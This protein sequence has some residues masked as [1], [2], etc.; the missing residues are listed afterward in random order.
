[1][2]KASQS[3]LPALF[4]PFLALGAHA[5]ATTGTSHPDDLPAVTAQ[6]DHYVPPSH[7]GAPQAAPS[8]QDS[9]P[10]TEAAPS[11]TPDR[12]LLS[13]DAATPAPVAPVVPA[14]DQY[15]PYVPPPT[16]IAATAPTGDLADGEIVTSVPMHPHE[17]NR[18]TLLH[19]VLREGL[20]TQTTIQGST[21]TA[22]L[23]ADVGH[24][25]EVM[26]PAGSLIR[27]HVSEVHGGKRI[28]GGAAM[29]LRPETISLPDGTLYRIDALITDL[30]STQDLKVNDE[31]TI[32]LRSN[33][34][35]AAAVVGGVT[36][37]AAITGAAVGGGV[38]AAVGAI[39]GAGVA[40]VVYLRREVQEILPARTN[41]I[42]ALDEPLTI[43]PR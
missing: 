12:R 2:T 38:G 29:H 4:L 5:Q 28:T 42:F 23:T 34:K 22:E 11:A 35:A 3:L 31:G 7:K 13:R 33:P 16:Q 26:L 8:Y 17:L 27:G 9:F 10:A 15:R 37:T 14:S 21:F 18:G 40:S 6:S 32:V 1:M 39:A 41:V 36:A 20:S 25:G 43:T 30:D 19:A 24:N